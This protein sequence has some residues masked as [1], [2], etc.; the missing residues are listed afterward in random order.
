AE[1]VERTELGRLAGLPTRADD[2]VDGEDLVRPRRVHVGYDEVLVL[3][4]VYP[5]GLREPGEDVDERRAAETEHGRLH[6]LVEAR[7]ASREESDL[8]LVDRADLGGA[9]DAGEIDEE[10]LLREGEV[11]L[12]QAVAPERVGRTRHQ[13]VLGI[14][15]D[16]PD[17]TRRQRDGD[18]VGSTADRVQLHLA[19]AAAQH[20]VE[21]GGDRTLAVQKDAHDGWPQ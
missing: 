10:E 17:R 21:S 18:A 12:Q 5:D 20:L 1:G 16:G 4:V 9:P 7:R 13:G 6:R 8:H 19:R 11:L 15:A 3:G 14:E 2:G